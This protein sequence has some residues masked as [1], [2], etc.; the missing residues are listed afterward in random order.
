MSDLLDI[1]KKFVNEKFAG[2]RGILGVLLTGSSVIGV[3]DELV[4]LDFEVIVADEYYEVSKCLADEA[5]YEG[6]EVCWGWTP[7]KML[8]SKL[9]GWYDDINLWVYSTAKIMYDPDNTVKNLLDGYREYLRI[10]EERKCSPTFSM[11]G[12]RHHTILRKPYTGR[13]R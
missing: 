3:R 2:C 4:D 7:L 13:I 8:K 11:G 5:K 9:N 12:L 6:F 1:A 10:F